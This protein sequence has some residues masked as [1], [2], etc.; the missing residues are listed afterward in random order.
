MKIL[1]ASG[2]TIHH[3]SRIWVVSFFG[4]SHLVDPWLRTEPWQRSRTR[5]H[6]YAW[7][8]IGLFDVGHSY[9][10]AR[11]GKRLDILIFLSFDQSFIGFRPRHVRASISRI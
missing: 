3:V 8:P 9:L 6:S 5:R 10:K 1:A 7:V 11:L 4:C 2:H